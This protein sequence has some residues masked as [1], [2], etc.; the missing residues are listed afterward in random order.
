MNLP[1][2]TQNPSKMEWP[3]LL[4]DRRL[5]KTPQPTP[6]SNG[7]SQF[8][9]DFDRI[10]YSS[11]FR[12]LQD[13]TQVFPLAKSDY[14]RKRL[15]HSL[16]VSCIGR[17]LG[18]AVGLDLK[19]RGIIDPEKVSPSDVGTIVAAACLAHDIGNPPFGHSGEDAIQQWVSESKHEILSSLNDWEKKD[20]ENFEGNAQGFRIL[21]RLQNPQAYGLQLTYATL[22]T[23]TKYPRESLIDDHATTHKGVSIKK[24]HGYFQSERPYFDEVAGAVGLIKRVSVSSC[25]SR[26]PLAFLVEAADDIANLVADLEDGFHMKKVS[27]EKVKDNLKSVINNNGKVDERLT[28]IINDDDKVSFLRAKAINTV[29]EQVAEFF[30]QKEE[31][32]LCGSFDDNIINHI[33]C[34]KTLRRIKKIENDEIF[35]TKDILEVEIPGF[36]VLGGLLEVFSG[37]VNDISENQRPSKKS[38]ALVKLIPPQFLGADG[39]PDPCPYPRLLQVTDFVSGMTDS[40]AVSLYKQIRGISLS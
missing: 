3:L 20:F 38:K 28:Q 39:N 25:W 35:P 21:T 6:S 24:K 1:P 11:A 8:H 37:A 36:A 10:V 17:T 32:I 29:V 15:T 9:K 13:K 22:G 12:R 5:R 14:V 34:A 7:R 4:S 19:A 18:T 33:Q 30:L 2:S 16:E 26:H 23:F 27:F 31:E 40:Y